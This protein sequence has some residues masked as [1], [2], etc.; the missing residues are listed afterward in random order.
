[1][2]FER[3]ICSALRM[4]VGGDSWIGALLHVHQGERLAV[5]GREISVSTIAGGQNWWSTGI[6][7]SP[8]SPG[9][10][11]C[12]G[13]LAHAVGDG[14]GC[15]EIVEMSWK[16]PRAN[17]C[18]PG[19]ETLV[20]WPGALLSTPPGSRFGRCAPREALRPTGAPLSQ[21]SVIVRRPPS[22]LRV[23]GLMPRGNAELGPPLEDGEGFFWLAWPGDHRIAL[24]TPDE[25]VPTPPTRLPARSTPS[26]QPPVVEPRPGRSPGPRV[27]PRIWRFVSPVAECR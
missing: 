6:M 5:E 15:G 26:G 27:R 8:G 13:L 24:Q 20:G 21:I 17:L 1:L 23:G 25:P 18:P 2:T 16:D 7:A 10:A 11:R 3:V 14:P 4:P 22:R 12:R 19:P 9:S